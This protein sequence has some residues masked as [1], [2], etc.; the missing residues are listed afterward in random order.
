MNGNPS[1]SGIEN[2]SNSESYSKLNNVLKDLVPLTQQ[3]KVTQFLTNVEI[4]DRLGGIVDDVR[5]AVMEYQVC[6][7]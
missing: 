7:R 5:D 2:P 6:P 4:A 3:G 1:L